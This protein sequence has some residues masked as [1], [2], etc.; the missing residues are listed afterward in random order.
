MKLT[1][2]YKQISDC[3]SS[4]TE[5]FISIYEKAGVIVL[6]IS[7]CKH[8][9]INPTGMQVAWGKISMVDGE[10]RLLANAL[11]DK[12]NQHF[13]LL[14]ERCLLATILVFSLFI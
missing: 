3:S 11:K 4:R 2:N 12:D 5:D 14:S 9:L 1:N 10:K 13:V 6:G 7:M 8:V